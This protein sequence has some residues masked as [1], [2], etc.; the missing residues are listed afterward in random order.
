LLKPTP[1]SHQNRTT[2]FKR[3]QDQPFSFEDN[4]KPG[5]NVVLIPT[6]TAHAAE[7]FALEAETVLASVVAQPGSEDALGFWMHN[8]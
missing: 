2:Q 4:L 8:A 3:W 7:D 5:F 1:Y 6:T